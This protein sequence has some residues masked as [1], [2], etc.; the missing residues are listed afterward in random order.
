MLSLC[1]NCCH[2]K[3]LAHHCWALK[4]IN[5]CKWQ[6]MGIPHCTVNVFSYL[7]SMVV[8]VEGM[9]KWPICCSLDKDGGNWFTIN[10]WFLLS[11]W[12]IFNLFSK[13]VKYGERGVTVCKERAGHFQTVV[14]TSWIICAARFLLDVYFRNQ[15]IW[16]IPTIL[17]SKLYIICTQ[18][19]L[20][21]M[22]V[23]PLIVSCEAEA[24]PAWTIKPSPREDQPMATL[25]LEFWWCVF[26][27]VFASAV[28][29]YLC[30]SQLCFQSL[31]CLL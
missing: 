10:K 20:K 17:W 28:L 5:L 1:A 13:G 4:R 2:G 19:H 31:L 14:L 12:G 24:L 21:Y 18:M 26:V 16:I 30:L 15:C 29:L 8:E 23:W 25:L 11:P 27:V 22:G 3:A 7:C 9:W 6:K